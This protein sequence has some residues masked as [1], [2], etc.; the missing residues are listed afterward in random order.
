MARP[1]HMIAL[2]AALAAAQSAAAQDRVTGAEE[3][4]LH[5][6]ACHGMEGRGDGPLAQQLQSPPRN[7]AR[8]AAENDGAYPFERV[9]SVIDGRRPVEG[10]GTEDMPI[11]GRRY[12]TEAIGDYGPYY[13]PIEEV[14]QGRILSLVYY[15]QTIQDETAE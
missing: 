1:F 5:C 14:V 13:Y 2:A 8:L 3:F 7:L 4:R 9:Y 11:W 10:H 15:I 6:A 12:A